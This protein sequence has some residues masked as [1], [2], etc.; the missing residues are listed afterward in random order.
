MSRWDHHPPCPNGCGELA[1]ECAC[2]SPNPLGSMTIEPAIGS[3][4][5][6][7]VREVVLTVQMPWAFQIVLGHK[8]VENRVWRP[9]RN[10]PYGRL[11]IHAG[12]AYD[13]SAHYRDQLTPQQCADRMGHIIG[14]ARVSGYHHADV[15][16]C[17]CSPWAMPDQWHWQLSAAHRVNPVPHRGRLGLWPLPDDFYEQEPING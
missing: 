17:D 11:W 12:K 7:D 16:G 5:R 9:T 2:P 3:A 14:F 4:A 10:L 13:K 6:P 8:D 15:C 1:D